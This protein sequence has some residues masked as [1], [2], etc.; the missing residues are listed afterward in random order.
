MRKTV[1]RARA[2]TPIISCRVEDERA[3]PTNI[4]N[5]VRL[6]LRMLPEQI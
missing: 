4:V 1:A 2:V 3:M 6:R 5:A